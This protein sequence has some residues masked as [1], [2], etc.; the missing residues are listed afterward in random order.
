MPK[1]MSKTLAGELA[2][3]AMTVVN[4]A[5]RGLTLVAALQRHGFTIGATP[6]ADRLADRAA[7]VAWL[8]ETYP[9]PD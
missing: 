7:I 6:P 9:K 3:R 4:P 1:R 5:N 2:D 8:T